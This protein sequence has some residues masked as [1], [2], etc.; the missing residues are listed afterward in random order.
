MVNELHP[1]ICRLLWDNCHA[2]MYD[3]EHYMFRNRTQKEEFSR[4][5]K[6]FSG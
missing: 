4:N 5:K 1:I 6:D 3:I 2:E